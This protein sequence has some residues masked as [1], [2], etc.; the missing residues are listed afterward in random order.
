[1]FLLAASPRRRA[2]RLAQAGQR[3]LMSRSFFNSQSCH[4]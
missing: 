3:I 1:L 2:V 4:F